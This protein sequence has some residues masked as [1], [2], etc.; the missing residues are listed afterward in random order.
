M[1]AVLLPQE[2]KA[3]KPMAVMLGG[4]SRKSGHLPVPLVMIVVFIVL[5]GFFYIGFQKSESFVAVR[6]ILSL[7]LED[8]KAI[9]N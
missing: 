4:L 5:D 7:S 2:P 6:E 9:L 8:V 3:Q 1:M